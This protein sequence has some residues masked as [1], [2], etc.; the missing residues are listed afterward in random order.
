[1]TT[2]WFHSRINSKESE[3]R[4]ISSARASI[5]SK[6]IRFTFVSIC[7]CFALVFTVAA[8][9]EWTE[10]GVVTSLE[11]SNKPINELKPPICTICSSGPTLEQVKAVLVNSFI[12]WRLDKKENL[13]KEDLPRLAKVFLEEKFQIRNQPFNFLD[14]FVAITRSEDLDQHLIAYGVKEYL[15]ECP[16][17]GQPTRRKRRSGMPLLKDTDHC[18]VNLLVSQSVQK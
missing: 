16:V 7:I 14:V 3:E 17:N 18:E 11:N 4:E 15:K 1:M 8:Y 9:R 13:G 6:L 5:V 12:Q 2:K 10:R